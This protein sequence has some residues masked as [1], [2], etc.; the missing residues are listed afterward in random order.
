M[1]D[2]GGLVFLACPGQRILRR[3]SETDRR[4]RIY[5]C[6]SFT[7]ISAI[8]FRSGLGPYKAQVSKSDRARLEASIRWAFELMP[9]HSGGSGVLTRKNHCQ[10]AIG[11]GVHD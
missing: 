3:D 8:G 1:R 5:G 11:L 9:I 6:N 10:Q 2:R 7:L 4:G